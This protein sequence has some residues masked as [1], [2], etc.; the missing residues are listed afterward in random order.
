MNLLRYSLLCTLVPLNLFPMEIQ[1]SSNLSNLN[2][3]LLIAA[4]EGDVFGITAHLTSGANINGVDEN[5]DTP[6]HIAAKHNKENAI[7]HLLTFKPN[8]QITNNK[9]ESANDAVRAMQYD[10]F[11]QENIK[12]YQKIF[13]GKHKDCCDDSVENLSPDNTD[14]IN[15]KILD[16]I[17]HYKQLKTP[18]WPIEQSFSYIEKYNWR[19]EQIIPLIK[20]LME[21]G[22]KPALVYGDHYAESPLHIVAHYGLADILKLLVKYAETLNPVDKLKNTPLHIAVKQEE[23]ACVAV[24]LQNG[25]SVDA[26]DE[27]GRTPLQNATFLP[28]HR[29]EIIGLLLQYNANPLILNKDGGTVLQNIENPIKNNIL[30]PI[31]NF[32]PNYLNQNIITQLKETEKKF[33]SKL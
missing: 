19:Y 13:R 22:A 7:I 1:D 14:N 26:T 2:Q 17:K 33:R 10:N 11:L 6:M 25:A 20:I 30:G 4:Q 3:K 5:G 15:K 31:I 24:L 29:D 32:V 9:G 16:C 8:L 28:N 27:N 21:N 12:K 18:S 23:T